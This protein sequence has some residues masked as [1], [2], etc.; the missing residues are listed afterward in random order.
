ML[1]RTTESRL[2]EE[3]R[4]EVGFEPVGDSRKRP[5]KER[6]EP[7]KTASSSSCFRL[8]YRAKLSLWVSLY[9][10]TTFSTRP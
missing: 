5:L 9:L 1:K 4:S 8:G 6:A 2:S 10:F 3:Q 7:Q